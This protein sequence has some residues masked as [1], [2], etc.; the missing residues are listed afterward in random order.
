[1]LQTLKRQRYR[2]SLIVNELKTA[3]LVPY[4]TTL[5]AFINCILV[6]TEELDDRIR[7]RNEFIGKSKLSMG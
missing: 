3:E 5:V 4:K 7:V 6:A 1:M 2:F